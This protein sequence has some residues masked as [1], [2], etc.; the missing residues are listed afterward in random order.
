MLAHKSL[1]VLRDFDNLL[2]DPFDHFTPFGILDRLQLITACFKSAHMVFL[3]DR[4]GDH[5]LLSEAIGSR[6]QVIVQI[7]KSCL[8]RFGGTSFEFASPI[9][10]WPLCP[11]VRPSPVPSSIAQ[12]IAWRASAPPLFSQGL[13]Q[14]CFSS[15]KANLVFIDN[16][17]K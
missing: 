11:S 5:T 9:A 4:A 15:Q 13:D 16:C 3:L 12:P 8:A 1:F 14:L 2:F 7:D 17:L 10:R 6:L